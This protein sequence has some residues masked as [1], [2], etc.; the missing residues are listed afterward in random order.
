MKPPKNHKNKDESLAFLF[1]APSVLLPSLL[2]FTLKSTR[3][4]Y[5]EVALIMLLTSSLLS[6]AQ[7]Q[8]RI[9]IPADAN[10]TRTLIDELEVMSD[11]QQKWSSESLFATSD[12]LFE[13]NTVDAKP[14]LH[15]YWARFDKCFLPS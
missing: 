3:Q 2:L 13:P 11:E 1:G 9:E 15:N 6:I 7:A 14:V 10:W 5:R 8:T 12:D 4:T